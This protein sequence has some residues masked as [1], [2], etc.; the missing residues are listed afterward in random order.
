MVLN[1]RAGYEQAFDG[2]DARKTVRYDDR[3][4]QEFLA[5]PEIV[6]SR[7]FPLARGTTACSLVNSA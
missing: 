3:K 6:R 4:V 7:V 5:H 2:F 1:K